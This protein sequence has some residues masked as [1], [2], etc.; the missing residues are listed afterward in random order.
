[1]NTALEKAESTAKQNKLDSSSLSLDSAIAVALDLAKRVLLPTIKTS[2]THSEA[3]E[4]RKEQVREGIEN[5]IYGLKSE[6]ISSPSLLDNLKSIE[7]TDGITPY[8]FCPGF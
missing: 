5:L 1:M 4:V 7:T 3:A 6:G 8:N 2:G